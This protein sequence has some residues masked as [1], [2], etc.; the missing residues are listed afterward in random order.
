MKK[1][2]AAAIGLMFVIATVVPAFAGGSRTA[3]N[4]NYVN[5][6][7]HQKIDPKKLKGQPLKDA[8]KACREDTDNYQ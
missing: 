1:A 3:A 4:R 6:V 7:C 5:G 8:W 2:G